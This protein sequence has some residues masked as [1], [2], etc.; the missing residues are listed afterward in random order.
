MAT[1]GANL[2]QSELE[3]SEQE[4][5]GGETSA[6]NAAE[7]FGRCLS[8]CEPSYVYELSSQDRQRIFNL[9]Y[10]TWVE[11][12]GISVED[13]DRRRKQSFWDSIAD[14]LPAWDALI[15][16]FNSKSGATIGH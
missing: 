4:H 8:G 16:E 2:Y 6:T 3:A 15:T 14:E 13:F 9:G 7:I 11:Q 1:D 5:F 12:R 10:Y